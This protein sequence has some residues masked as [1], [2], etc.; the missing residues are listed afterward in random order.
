MISNPF[1]YA[2]ETPGLI[3]PLALPLQPSFEFVG[4]GILRIF[5]RAGMSGNAT[6]ES[7]FGISMYDPLA[8]VTVKYLKTLRLCLNLVKKSDGYHG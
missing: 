3:T 2:L 6:N 1:R 5:N 8:P 4:D 7:I